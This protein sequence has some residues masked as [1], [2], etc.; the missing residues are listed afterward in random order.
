MMASVIEM[1][2]TR[3]D[4][5]TTAF[6]GLGTQVGSLSE[7]FGEYRRASSERMTRLETEVQGL[8]TRMSNYLDPMYTSVMHYPPPGYVPS[9]PVFP[10]PDGGPYPWRPAPPSYF[11]NPYYFHPP[12]PPSDPSYPFFPLEED[13]HRGRGE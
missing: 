6:A 4:S 12:P 1:M 3:M 10:T 5:L 2:G 13:A 8:G 9:R 7:E 11:P